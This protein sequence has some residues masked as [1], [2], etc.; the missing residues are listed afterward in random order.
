MTHEQAVETLYA[1]TRAAQARG[2]TRYEIACALAMRGIMLLQ[3][4]GDAEERRGFARFLAEWSRMLGPDA[5]A[6]LPH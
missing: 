3:E 5:A 6:P 1:F 4:H 2:L